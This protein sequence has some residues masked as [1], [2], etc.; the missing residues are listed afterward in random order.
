MRSLHPLF[1]RTA[2]RCLAADEALVELLG[3]E[4]GGVRILG[5]ARWRQLA[6][7]E[8]GDDLYFGAVGFAI[9]RSPARLELS[10]AYGAIVQLDA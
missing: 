6:A 8:P 1:P 9:D 2:A 3:A 7:A 5:G 4:L 10:L